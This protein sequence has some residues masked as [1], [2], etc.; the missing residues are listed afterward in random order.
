MFSKKVAAVIIT[1]AAVAMFGSL[2]VQAIQETNR[3]TTVD[4]IETQKEC[5]EQAQ[6]ESEC[7]IIVQIGPIKYRLT[8]EAYVAYQELVNREFSY[9]ALKLQSDYTPADEQFAVSIEGS[10]DEVTAVIKDYGITKLDD[11]VNPENKHMQFFGTISKDDLQQFLDQNT[12]ED[13]RTK[14][15][16]VS[17]L[18][19]YTTDEGD[20]GALNTFITQSQHEAIAN[21]LTLFKQARLNDIVSQASGVEKLVQ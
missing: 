4:R 17:H 8:G 3:T 15:I 19:G 16:V 9:Q 14:D 12:I 10:V 6:S 20:S 5:P 1:I 18:G 7:S 2:G 13:L 21:E 11:K